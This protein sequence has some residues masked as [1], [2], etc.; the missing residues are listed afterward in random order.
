MR[1]VD[2]H[3][4]LN[5]PAFA[6]DLPA[7]VARAEEAGVARMVVAGYDLPS[8]ARAVALAERF[9]S[10][11]AAVGVSPHEA[12]TWC[13]EVREDLL[14][15]ARGEKVVAVGEIGLDYHYERAA[16][17][18][19]REV[20]RAQ[21]EMA[22]FLGLPVV[23]HDREAHAETMAIL[24]EAGAERVGGVMHC[25]SGSPETARDAFAMGF[26]IS[27][28]GPITFKNAFRPREVARG[29]PLAALLC[30]TDAPYLAPHP[31]RGERNEPALL[32]LNLAVLAEIHG[33][34]PEDMA[35]IVWE[36]AERIFGFARRLG[37]EGRMQI[38]YELDGALYLNITN[39]C[40]NRCSFCVRNYA[41]GVG[42]YD[43]WL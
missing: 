3:V 5:D 36:N 40:P 20:F 14:A 22:A 30:E 39:A 37:A 43:L 38:A 18:V 4:H 33:L 11:W 23:V 42:G 1:L 28:A 8:S 10:V 15:L 9:P 41:P 24:R 34:P 16:R 25:F 31:R 6:E 26:G 27:F 2:V 17:A 12:E 32:G 7:V 19:Q 21:L 29:L 35:W 13:E